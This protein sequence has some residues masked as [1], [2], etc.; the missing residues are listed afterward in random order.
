MNY[1]KNCDSENTAQT[2]IDEV[3]THLVNDRVYRTVTYND[4]QYLV[5]EYDNFVIV[6]G[7]KTAWSHAALDRNLALDMMFKPELVL[8][9][10][11]NLG[12]QSKLTSDWLEKHGY[13]PHLKNTSAYL[14]VTSVERDREFVLCLS[15]FT[16][17]GTG[18][19]VIYLD[20]THVFKI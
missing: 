4:R 2:R 8:H 6:L 11:N 1:S 7:E 9:V 13:P 12:K 20:T 14:T 18:E 19:E 10:L 15:E 3:S 17:D 5:D 16:Y